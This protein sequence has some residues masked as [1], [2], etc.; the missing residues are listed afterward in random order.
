[1]VVRDTGTTWVAQTAET[2]RAAG[3]LAGMVTGP[4]ADAERAL[5]SGLVDRLAVVDDPTDPTQL[6]DAAR[7]I[8][9]GHRLGALYS[10]SD[11]A[12]VAAVRA[13][14]LLGIGRTPSAGL[15]TAR[16]KYAARRAMAEAGLPTPRFALIHDA[17][18]AETVAEAVSLPA[19]VK[20][21]TGAG[22][23]LVER[24]ST[25]AELAAVY[26]TIADRLLDVPQLRHLYT[27]PVDGLD[28]RTTF[29]V[30]GML[31]GHEYCRDLVVRDGEVEL[32]PLVDKFLVDERFFERGFISPP[33]GLDPGLERDIDAA[34]TDAVLAIGLDNTVACVEVIVDEV[35]G[36]TVVEVNC[37][38]GGQLMGT[39]YDLRTGVNTAAEVIGLARGVPAARTEPKLPIPL[40]T[41]TFFPEG[42]GRLRAVH[43]LDDLAELPDVIRVV[44]S[45][46]PG[47]L[48]TD[49]YEIFAVNVVV[50]GFADED[51]LAGVYAEAAKL[52]RFDL[53]PL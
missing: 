40:G 17:S 18:E 11:G 35:L 49:D 31:R 1:M 34:V 43:G 38:P 2:I 15:A 53:D 13:A 33:L 39:L 47:D 23:H 16:N 24:V 48:I 44:S 41:L 27:A 46:A 12:V 52:V 30:E 14:E 28:P 7:E 51:D 5:L 3:C 26:R 4:V 9:A 21:V 29:L 32:L 10:S 50:A 36:P 19:V 8:A 37:R 22:S 45:V 25:V 6:A 20:P 42:T